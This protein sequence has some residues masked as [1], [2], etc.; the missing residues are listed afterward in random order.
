MRA[1]GSRSQ[2]VRLDHMVHTL[3]MP[4]V[5]T[6]VVLL[7]VAVCYAVAKSRSADTR[8]WSLLGLLLGPLAIPFVFFS[9]PK[10]DGEGR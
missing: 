7:S 9:R 6:F 10:G 4:A 2:T 8:F 3:P 1:S 5:L